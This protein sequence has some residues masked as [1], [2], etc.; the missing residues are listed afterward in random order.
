VLAE[1]VSSHLGNPN[2]GHVIPKH[3]CKPVQG[4]FI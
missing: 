3:E 1:A 2:I 4:F